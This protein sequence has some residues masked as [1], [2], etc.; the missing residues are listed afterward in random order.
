MLYADDIVLIGKTA[1]EL[2]E[3][4]NTWFTEL[5][6]HGLRISRTK[7]EYME[8]DL[9][10]TEE[11]NC[12]IQIENTALPKVERFKYLG[13]MLTTDARVDEDV[14]H[15]VNT[16]WLKWRSLSGVLCDTRMPVKTK[17]KIYKTAVRPAMLYGAE[18]WTALKKHEQ[19]LHTAEMK[20]L[21]WAGGRRNATGQSPQ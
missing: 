19:Q 13:S 18:C 11:L 16:A 10:G 15:R 6:K 2:Q 21:R 12:E 8:C 3:T 17:G 7:T 5:E 9:G 20:M 1:P 14:N 4:F